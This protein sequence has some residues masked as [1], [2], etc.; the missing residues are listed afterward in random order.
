MPQRF[1]SV[2]CV[3]LPQN[4]RQQAFYQLWKKFKYCLTVWAGKR[5]CSAV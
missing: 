1:P 4:G 5:Q 3:Q 2:C